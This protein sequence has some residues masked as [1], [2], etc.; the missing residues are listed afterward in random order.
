MRRAARLGLA[1][2]AVAMLLSGCVTPA[3]STSAY[4]SKAGMTAEAADSAASTALVATRAYLHRRMGSAYL[5]T[6]L[7]DAEESLTSV[8]DTFDSVQPPATEAADALRGTLD[9]LL[10]NAGSALT[11]LRIAG[12]RNSSHDLR[13][14]AGALS[15]VAARLDAFGKQ[16]AS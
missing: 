12:R 16:H 13:T 8:H 9:P 14:A 5:E 3:P 10:E 6:L 1:G 7:V 11:D 2:A 4:E 15:S